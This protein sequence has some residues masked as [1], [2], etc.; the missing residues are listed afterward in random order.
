VSEKK[1]AASGKD[2]IYIDAD[3]EITG[4]IDK[5][6]AS[7]QKLVALV[8]PKRATV[9]QSIVNMKLLK[10]SATEGKKQLVLI[11][12]EA[13][14][15]PL[16]GA[17]GLHVAKSLQS[18]PEIPDAPDKPIA[19]ETHAVELPG[20]EEAPADTAKTVGELS[21]E[22]DET[23]ELDDEPESDD[24]PAAEA[25]SH[26]KGHKGFKIPNFNKFR[27]L[28]IAGAAALVALIVFGVLGFM[29]WPKAEIE[30][31]TDS[32]AVESSLDVTLKT[33]PE[34]TLDV[35]TNVVPA[36]VQESKKTISQQVAAT[37]QIDKGSKATGD[38]TLKL[39]D[40]STAQVKVPAGTGL[41]ASGLTFITTESA[42]LDSVKV[43][44]QCKN[45]SFPNFSTATVSVVAQNGGEQYNIPAT[46]YKVLGYSNVTGEGT[47]MTGGTTDI[48]KVVSQADID[49]AKQKIAEQDAAQVKD[50]LKKA[51]I[52]KDLFAI[53]STYA[54]TAPSTK[55]SANVGDHADVVTVTQEVV[56]SMLGA[57]RDD[58]EKVIAADA[59]KQIDSKKQKILEYGLDEATINLQNQ[60]PEGTVI[61]LASTVIAGPELDIANIKKQVAGK[62]ASVAQEII[63]KNPGVTDVTVKYSPFWVS[64]IPAKTSKIH[65]TV[66]KPQI[67]KQDAAQ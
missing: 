20:E 58:L 53:E 19:D 29:V 2:V 56:Y 39:T 9:L 33:A 1:S 45:D 14:L 43:G 17:V 23:I 60:K 64:A 67:D 5:V 3:E 24:S 22:A 27:L 16:A 42:T 32:T 52:D 31:K 28:I 47:P 8:L 11:T 38:V 6:L 40:C 36:Q 46:S 4:M 37:G 66:E 25:K 13:S 63:K 34:T 12:S 18:K 61:T 21:G 10:R 44:N 26:G 59:N 7:D 65:I 57:K 51:L 41:T 15:L 50:E 30:V 49:S 55:Q 62:K 48:V 35:A 54:T